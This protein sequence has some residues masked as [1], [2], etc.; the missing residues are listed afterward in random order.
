MVLMRKRR[1]VRKRGG[2]RKKAAIS[3]PRRMMRRVKNGVPEWASLSVRDSAFNGV[4]V[5]GNYLTNTM[6]AFNQIRLSDFR[7]AVQV[8]AAYQFY[9]IKQVKITLKYPYDT[10]QAGANAAARPNLYFMIDKG[11]VLPTTSTLLTLK[12]AG[13]RPF[14][15]DNKPFTITFSPAVLQ[16]V[17]ENA[18]GGGQVPTFKRVAPWLNTNQSPFSPGAFVPS[19]VCHNGVYWF[20]EQ[21]NGGN[22]K[23]LIDIEVQFQFKKPLWTAVSNNVEAVQVRIGKPDNSRDGVEGGIDHVGL[24]NQIINHTIPIGL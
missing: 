6:Y 21:L 16:E 13:A 18:A 3:R 20:V 17:N 4:D 2:L 5:S 19:D 9:R 1:V 15:I 22:L 8:A 14:A 12:N 7:R 11:G 10:Y 24:V 23:Y